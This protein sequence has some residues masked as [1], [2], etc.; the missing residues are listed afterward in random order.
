MR[1]HYILWLAV[2]AWSCCGLAPTTPSTLAAQQTHRVLRVVDGDTVVLAELGTTRLIGVDT[3]ETVDPRKPVQAFGKEASAFLS[4]LLSGQT[5]RVEFEGAAK[6]KYGRTLAYLYLADG[7]F[8]NAE[9]IRQG[10]GH[11]YT[12]FP[13]K[14]IPEFLAFEREAREARRGLWANAP[15]ARSP[16]SS[17]VIVIVTRTGDKY[18]RPTCPTLRASRIEL[19]VATAA[20]R[21]QPCE[22]CKPPR[23]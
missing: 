13:F 18:H 1:R 19:P 11:A 4:T 7:T 3:P 5:V 20:A 22:V 23:P 9:I 14:F 10:Y 17:E 15:A 2:V 8:V 6:D 21:Y 12:Q 16:I